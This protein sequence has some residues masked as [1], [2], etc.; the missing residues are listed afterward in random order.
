MLRGFYSVCILLLL[1]LSLPSGTVSSEYRAKS[2]QLV[3]LFRDDLLTMRVNNLTLKEVLKEISKQTGIEI[4]S[5]ASTEMPVSADFSDLVLDEGLKRLIRDFSFI[6]IYNSEN[7][8]EVRT[9]LTNVLIYPKTY[10]ENAFGQQ[11]SQPPEL[12]ENFQRIEMMDVLSRPEYEN[13][14]DRLTEVFLKNEDP[15]VRAIEVD[16]LAILRDGRDIDVL[17][18]EAVDVDTDLMVRIFAIQAL[19]EI[20]DELAVEVLTDA[21]SDENDQVKKYAADAL[22]SLEERDPSYQ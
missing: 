4:F 1:T 14:F 7:S 13:A 16:E 8:K 19:G 6:F 11:I 5:Y 15:D 21:L 10:K 20:G 18:Q 2:G 3:V 22:R 12:L 17:I 9:T